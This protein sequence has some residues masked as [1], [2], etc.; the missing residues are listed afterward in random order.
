MHNPKPKLKLVIVIPCLAETGIRKTLESLR[1]KQS[2]DFLVE[3]LVVVNHSELAAPETKQ[4]N[5]NIFDGLLADKELFHHN[6]T[7]IP[8][9]AFDLPEKKAGVGMA[10]KIGMDMA[11]NRLKEAQTFK[12]GI[13]VCLDGDCTVQENYIDEIEKYFTQHKV[14]GCSI[15]FEHPLDRENSSGIIDYELFLRYYTDALRWCGFPYAFQTVGSSMAVSANAYEKQ[16]GMNTRKAGEDFY[17]LNKIIQLERFG[18]LTMTTVFPSSRKSDRVPFGTGREMMEWEKSKQLVAYSPDLFIELKKVF[19]LVDKLREYENPTKLLDESKIHPAIISYLVREQFSEAVT[20]A[21]FH[22]S[23]L[24]SFRKRF[25]VWM[26]A[27][28]IMKLLNELSINLFPK[29]EIQEGASWL[30]KH[31]SSEDAGT[32][33][34]ALL[35][36]F[37][38][39]D[40][41]NSISVGF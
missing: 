20:E 10:R 3:C 18:D 11:I 40:R 35:L 1:P 4:I 32:N 39:F 22:T 9:E 6:L 17:F 21:R 24:S 15:Y 36:Q 8:I 37:R 19:S 30:W 25:F 34:Q 14:N 41:R 16:G 2:L 28:R 26:N 33:S 5:K 13:L 12:E 27:F 7:V 23:T 31:I 29:I 38:N